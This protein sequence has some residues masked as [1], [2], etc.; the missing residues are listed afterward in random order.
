MKLQFIKL[1]LSLATIKGVFG[2]CYTSIFSFG[3]SLTDTGN[4][5]FT[6]PTQ[7]CRCCNG[8]LVL[9]FTAQTLG[10]PLIKPYLGFENGSTVT[11]IQEGVNFAVV[12]ATA[13]DAAF[14]FERG[15]DNVSTN[16]SLSVQMDW[17]KKILPSLCNSNT[18]SGK[19]T[20]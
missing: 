17:F 3:D 18:S 7:Q 1:F 11:S 10:L 9:D 16:D 15:I 14:F 8:R 5:Y 2:N 4:I 13:L 19:F 20:I 6:D 12:G